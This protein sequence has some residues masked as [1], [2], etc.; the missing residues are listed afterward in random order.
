VVGRVLI[1]DNGK[2]TN[3]VPSVDAIATPAWF[4]DVSVGVTEV[5]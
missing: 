1:P 2:S 3:G 4:A 5:V